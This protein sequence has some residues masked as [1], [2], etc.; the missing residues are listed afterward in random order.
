MRSR[1]VAGLVVVG[2][3]I[4]VGLGALVVWQPWRDE[5]EWLFTYAADSAA[6]ED[7][8]SGVYRVRFAGGDGQLLAFTDRPDRDVTSVDLDA[9]ELLWPTVFDGSNPNAVLVEQLP[10]SE[11][12]SVVVEILDVM[13]AD[14]ELAMDVRV[15]ADDRASHDLSIARQSWVEVPAKVG[16]VRLFIDS[17]K[18]PAQPSCQ[19][20][21][22]PYW[23]PGAG[24]EPC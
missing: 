3:L 14:S 6:L 16:P 23:P 2:V 11:R 9:L 18:L 7:Q 13:V 1:W 8:G 12:D 4:A 10:D 21:F 24:P 5:P 20:P 17:G 19:Q 15:L 22:M